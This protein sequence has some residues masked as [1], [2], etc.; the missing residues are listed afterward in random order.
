[1]LGRCAIV[2]LVF[3]CILH[4][5]AYAE[6]SFK[7]TIQFLAGPGSDYEIY[8]EPV[9]NVVR[10]SSYGYGK[11]FKIV[12]K[13]VTSSTQSLVVGGAD[14][15]L[16]LITFEITDD[17]G[18]SNVVTKKIDVSQSRGEGFNYL[19]PGKAKE[20]MIALSEQEWNNVFKLARQGPTRLSARAT[21]KNGSTVIYSDYY[22]ILP[23]E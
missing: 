22:T 9:R 14:K 7:L 3:V 10:G 5:A 2:L 21:Y 15:G 4:V 16:G 8:R 12:L 6:D 20:F 19:S 18:N 1:M 23:D 13:N 11:P 17:K